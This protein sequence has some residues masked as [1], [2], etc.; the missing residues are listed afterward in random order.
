MKLSE[1]GNW[2]LV[3]S[4]ENQEGGFDI[5]HRIVYKEHPRVADIS[6]AIVEISED[7]EFAIPKELV[8]RLMID[9]VSME[10][11]LNTVGDEDIDPAGYEEIHDE[12]TKE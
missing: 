5:V 9:I 4:Y 11:W 10:H 7:E 1:F 8:Q 6:H 2:I 3:F 12:E